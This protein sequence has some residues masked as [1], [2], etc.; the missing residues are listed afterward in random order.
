M[1]P[2]PLTSGEHAAFLL[3]VRSGEIEAGD[4][5]P[6]IDIPLAEPYPVV[7]VRDGLENCLVGVNALVLLV[8]VCQLHGLADVDFAAVRLLQPHDETEQCGLSG[9]VR[10]DDSDNAGRRKHE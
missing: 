2:V 5:R 1:E 10:S 7:A 8:H 3:L 9:A 4:V 6:C